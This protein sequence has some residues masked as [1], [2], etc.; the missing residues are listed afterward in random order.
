LIPQILYDSEWTRTPYDAKE[1]Y[2]F[3]SVY[4]R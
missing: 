3:V 4:V 2:C 1:P